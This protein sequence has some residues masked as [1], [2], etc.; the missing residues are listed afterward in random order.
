MKTYDKE[1]YY[2]CRFVIMFTFLPTFLLSLILPCV[3]HNHTL[4]VPI[5]FF[6]GDNFVHRWLVVTE[7][8]PLSFRE[9]KTFHHLHHSSFLFDVDLCKAFSMTVKNKA[10]KLDLPQRSLGLSTAAL[11]AGP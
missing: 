7:T 6:E 11:P 10:E 2:F 8:L 4:C 5:Y 1:D 9:C 3:V